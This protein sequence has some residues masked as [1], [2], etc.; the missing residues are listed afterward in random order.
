MAEPHAFPH[1][2]L[3]TCPP[4]APGTHYPDWP[5]RTTR[6]ASSFADAHR[7]FE[8]QFITQALR[9][10]GGNISRTARAIG[11]TRRNLQVKIQKLGIEVEN[12]RSGSR[13]LRDE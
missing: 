10:N 11:M 4:P 2:F 12:L 8:T 3:Q 7:T 6:P 5:A 1:L 13:G 9:D